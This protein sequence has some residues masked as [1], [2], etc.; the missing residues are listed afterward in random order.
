[1]RSVKYLPLALWNVARVDIALLECGEEQ[2]NRCRVIAM[3]PREENRY[4]E[5]LH[6]LHGALAC[7]V[8]GIVKE[9]DS[10]VSPVHIF[11]IQL[12][13]QLTNKDLH[14]SVVAVSLQQR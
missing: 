9:D 4:S 12:Q 10:A 6:Q 2:F 1:M 5:S 3:R 13:H 11:L 8:R 7:M 14:H